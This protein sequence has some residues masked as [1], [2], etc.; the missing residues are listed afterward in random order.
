MHSST[1]R[2]IG[3]AFSILTALSAA[4]SPAAAP[5]PTS[6]PAA[7]PTAAAAP[8]PTTAPAAAPTTAPAPTAAAAAKPTT[9]PAAAPTTAAAAPAPAILIKPAPAGRLEIFSW[10]TSGGESAGLNQL[11]DQYKKQNPGVDIVNATVAGGAGTNAK[12]VLKT[13]M[14]GGDPPDS[15]QVHMGHELTDTWVVTEKM[16]PLDAIYTEMGFDKAFPK[17]VLDIVSYQGHPYSVP[18]N[19]H[20]ANVLWYNKKVFADNN[21]QAPVTFDDFF[22]AAETLKAKGITPLAFGNKEGFEGV[23]T[24]ETTAIGVLGAD[25]Y[26]GL[27][28]GKTAWTDPKVTETLNTYKKLLSYTNTDSAGLTWDQ[29]NDLVISGKAGMTIMGDW[30]D[31]DYTAK[32]FT[33]YGWTTTPGNKGIY[34]ALSDTFGLPKGV[35][36][37]EQVKNWLRLIGTAEAQDAFNP[38]K[39]SVPVNINA[40]KGNYDEYLKSAIQDWKTQT[41]VPSLAHGA[42]ASEGWLT[43]ITDAMTVFVTKQDVA[44]TQSALQQACVDAKVCK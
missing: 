39:G 34:D 35:K 37:V 42:A 25:G 8:K 38:L 40:G 30:I 26:N 14:L 44:S 28:T 31:G 10:W 19:I 12:A 4:C 1:I 43:S 9:A 22:K 11:F 6:A 7:A 5:P 18:V 15:F 32:K 3:V 23:Q 27:W 17:G 16:E 41:V 24:F 33:D 36:D 29:A 2:R 13:R 20:R 21:L